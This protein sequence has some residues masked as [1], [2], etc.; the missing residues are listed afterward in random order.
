M[1]APIVTTKALT[2]DY[3]GGAGLHG[4]DLVVPRHGVYGLVGPNGAG[5]TTLLSILAGLRRPG[6]GEVHL[7]V[8][9]ARVASCPD[10][11]AFEPFLTAAEVVGQSRGLVFGGRAGPGPDV[12]AEV[13]LAAA[14]GRRVGGFSRGMTQRL[15]LAVALTLEPELLILDEPTSA[16]DP[17]GRAELL[18]L[19]ARLARDRTVIFSSHILADVQRVAT[20]IGVLD[21]GRLLFQG[22]T[23]LLLDTYLKP[24]WQVRVRGDAG[25]LAGR[26]RAA[27]WVTAVVRDDDALLVEA[28]SS[29]AGESGLPGLI[30]GAGVRLVS[31]NPVD[32]DLETAFLALTGN[33]G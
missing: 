2:R 25:D 23:R 29:E 27:D 28:V 20:E 18:T 9:S 4:V 17:A 3:G 12:L 19:I 32:A 26:L 30:A 1:T 8:P 11:P 33:H 14:A 31:L 15:G 24:A 7:A 10:T 21:H 13:G 6:S 22:P 5:K 16:L